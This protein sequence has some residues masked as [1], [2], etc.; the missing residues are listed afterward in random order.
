VGGGEAADAEAA[1][2]NNV[3]PRRLILSP[4]TNASRVAHAAATATA[5]AAAA[6]STVG[7]DAGGEVAVASDPAAGDATGAAPDPMYHPGTAVAGSMESVDPSLYAAY[8]GGPQMH[9]PVGMLGPAGCPTGAPAFP[10][11]P[12]QQWMMFMQW[13][14]QWQSMH[15]QTFAAA[16]AAGGM[17]LA[18]PVCLPLSANAPHWPAVQMAGAPGTEGT[19]QQTTAYAHSVADPSC[20]DPQGQAEATGAGTAELRLSDVSFESNHTGSSSSLPSLPEPPVCI[21]GNDDSF[22]SCTSLELSPAALAGA[23]GPVAGDA[24]SGR[25]F[26]H[27]TMSSHNNAHSPQGFDEFTPMSMPPHMHQHSHRISEG[28]YFANAGM[29]GIP[30]FYP[31]GMLPEAWNMQVAARRMRNGAKKARSGLPAAAPGFAAA[32]GTVLKKKGKGD[33]PASDVSVLGGKPRDQATPTGGVATAAPPDAF[34]AMATRAAKVTSRTKAADSSARNL[35]GSRDAWNASVAAFAVATAQCAWRTAVVNDSISI[36]D[37]L[38]TVTDLCAESDVVVALQA[39]LRQMEAEV[40]DN[41]CTKNAEPCVLALLRNST[42]AAVQSCTVALAALGLGCFVPSEAMLT[43]CTNVVREKAAGDAALSQADAA[44]LLRSLLGNIRSART[45]HLPPAAWTPLYALCTEISRAGYVDD[46]AGFISVLLSRRHQQHHQQQTPQTHDSSMTA[47]SSAP[48]VVPGFA[49][50]RM[51]PF[52]QDGLQFLW[53]WGRMDLA[54]DCIDWVLELDAHTLKTHP[55]LGAAVIRMVSHRTVTEAIAAT[56]DALRSADAG[57][58]QYASL[59]CVSS[60]RQASAALGKDNTTDTVLYASW[61]ALYAFPRNTA[62]PTSV[63]EPSPSIVSALLAGIPSSATIYNTESVFQSVESNSR[64]LLEYARALLCQLSW[65]SVLASDLEKIGDAAAL[66]VVDTEIT[67][68]VQRIQDALTSMG[69]SVSKER[70][71]DTKA[72]PMWRLRLYESRILLQVAD[73]LSETSR[74][75]PPH[76]DPKEMGQR[77]LQLLQIPLEPGVSRTNETTLRIEEA[78]ALELLGNEEAARKVYRSALFG[79]ESSSGKPEALSQKGGQHWKLYQAAVLF[80]L[81]YGR[82]DA[83]VAIIQSGLGIM[84]TSSRVWALALQVQTLVDVPVCAVGM[85]KA[86]EAISAVLADPNL[87]A[88][89]SCC[90]EGLATIVRTRTFPTSCRA[91]LVASTLCLGL[92]RVKRSGELWTEAARLHLSM[93][94]PNADS[95]HLCLKKATLYTQ[96]YGDAFVEAIRSA[97]ITGSDVQALQR[98]AVAADTVFGAS[99]TFSRLFPEMGEPLCDSLKRARSIFPDASSSEL[100]VSVDAFLKGAGL[101]LCGAIAPL[102][103]SEGTAISWGS[104]SSFNRARALYG[105]DAL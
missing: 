64:V 35:I 11:D 87:T 33:K 66:T 36:G 13:Q 2:C 30:A 88:A 14:M 7:S 17:G 50:W 70:P 80:E 76:A 72:Q 15:M 79:S 20:P 10:F 71:N 45:G 43:A 8:A 62:C 59:K 74:P 84:S 54:Q 92:Y 47:S 3:K 95:V 69:N 75:L 97:G 49:G 37:A 94:A 46:A 101:V 55:N 96:Q 12:Q 67:S 99:F 53:R 19:E 52:I 86:I 82:I 16:A 27:A 77:A 4:S 41:D 89:I 9:F 60:L 93:Q 1:F 31:A 6:A 48:A 91:T 18:P 68:I 39:L 38:V 5:A 51:L 63:L 42:S 57:L 78:R 56:F 65:I 105:G 98:E 26:V 44:A 28:M 73:L 85:D 102:V 103:K 58:S 40:L 104:L 32:A 24:A 90:E 29:D 25:R 22:Q 83:A 61:L 21:T 34:T 81:R 23:D 100:P